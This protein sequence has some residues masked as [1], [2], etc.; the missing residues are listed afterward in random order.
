MAFLLAG[1]LSQCH[2]DLAAVPQ[3]ACMGSVRDNH[4]WH[5]IAAVLVRRSGP[6]SGYA[7]RSGAQ[8][9]GAPDLW[10]PGA[11]LARLGP[12]LASLRD[13][14]PAAGRAGDTTGCLSPQYRQHGLLRRTRPRLAL[15]DLSALFC[16]WRD[17]LR[18]RDGL[19]AYHPTACALWAERFHHHAPYR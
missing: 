7:A 12:S 15:D 3:P 16:S 19:D 8:P 1:A 9:A 2:G 14:L 4:L 17:L 18:F 11:G 13:D 5:G 10:H 6:R